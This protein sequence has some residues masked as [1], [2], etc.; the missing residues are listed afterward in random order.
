[1]AALVAPDIFFYRESF[2]LN[3]ANNLFLAAG[4]L[5]L[6]IAKLSNNFFATILFAMVFVASMRA[7]GWWS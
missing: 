2:T 1:M 7:I 5:S 6:L 3:P 4:I